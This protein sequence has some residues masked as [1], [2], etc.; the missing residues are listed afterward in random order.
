MVYRHIK[1]IPGPVDHVIFCIPAHAIPEVLEDCVRKGV[2]SAAIF[3]SGFRESEAPEGATLQDRIQ[4]IAHSGNIRILGPNCMG[5]YC[6]ETGLNFRADLPYAPG[7]IAMVSQSGGMA[8]RTIFHGVEK[9]L[10]FSKVVSYGNEVDLQSWE[11]LDYLAWDDATR[12]ILVYIEG[13]RNGRALFHSLKAATRQKPV[14]VLKGGL[15]QE[16]SRAASSHTGSMAGNDRLWQ[17]MLRQAKTHVV[18]DV[19]DLVDTAMTFYFLKRPAGRRI[20]LMC[21]SGG[22]IVNY[23]DLAALHGFQI[24]AFDPDTKSALYEIIHDPGTSCCNPIDMASLFFNREIYAPLFQILNKDHNTDL[25]L[26]VIAMEYI[27]AL[28][29]KYQVS[30]RGLIRAFLDIVSKVTKPFVVVIPPVM[31]E[32]SRLEV[33][34]AFLKVRIPTF[35]TMEGALGALSARIDDIREDPVGK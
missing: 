23:T 27:K 6:P 8:I 32:E 7:S 10:G 22:L 34:R 14:I 21:I 29:M 2:R 5:L 26:F 13:T 35:I 33:E 30:L 25:I 24:P 18:Q 28:E 20:A 15:C 3:S 11:L 4:E 1:E 9:G 17:I 31:E 19:S 12:L 16:G